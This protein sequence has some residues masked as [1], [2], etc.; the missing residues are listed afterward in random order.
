M[1]KYEQLSSEAQRDGLTVKE[2]PLKHTKGITVGSRIGIRTGQTS[3]EKACI[4]AEEIAHAKYTVGN[5]L[6]QSDVSNRKQELFARTKAYD[7]LIGL[8]GIIQIFENHCQNV[9]EAAELLGVTEEF[10]TEAL[11]RYRQRYGTHAVCGNY[12]I[13]FEPW[14]MVTKLL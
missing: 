4:L 9:Y 13:Q 5:I 1:T 3:T 8:T 6:D 12:I 2:L 14:L 7:Q 10:L 11:E